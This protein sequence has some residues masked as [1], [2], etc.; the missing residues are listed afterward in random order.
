MLCAVGI[1]RLYI[2]A[3]HV[4]LADA[5]QVDAG[6]IPVV[7]CEFVTMLFHLLLVA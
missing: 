2:M 1:Y 4:V 6:R 3:F 7:T 5:A